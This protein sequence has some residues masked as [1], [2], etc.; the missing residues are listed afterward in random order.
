ML[1]SFDTMVTATRAAV[2][3]DPDQRCGIGTDELACGLL[4]FR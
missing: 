1:R 4:E 2:A 3:I